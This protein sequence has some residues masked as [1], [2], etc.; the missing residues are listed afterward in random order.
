MAT[1]KDLEDPWWRLNNLYYIK[2]KK[3][4]KVLFKAN[5]AQRLFYAGMWYLN[6]VLKAR[7]LGLTT[8]IQLFM[9]DRCLFTPNI[10]AGV[11]AHNR[12]DAQKFFRDK[13]KFAY[14]NL[15]QALKDRIQATNDSAGELVFS[16][17]SSIR[18]GTSMRSGTL[19]Y[20]HISEFGKTCAKFPEKAAEII[21]GALNTVAPGQFVFIESTAEGDFGHFRD[22]CKA[23]EALDCSGEQLTTMDYKFFFFPWWKHPDYVLDADVLISQDLQDYFAELE[24]EEGIVLTREQKAWYAKKDAEQGANMRQEYPATSTEAFQKIVEGAIYGKEMRKAMQE[25]RIIHLPIDPTYKVFTFWDLGKRDTNSIWFMQ[26]IGPWYHWIDYYAN[27]LLGPEHYAKVL[28]ER[29][30]QYGYQYA[31]HYMPHDVGVEDYSAVN[32]SRQDIYER[33]GVKPIMRVQRIPDLELGINLTR[34]MLA[35]SRFDRERCAEGIQGLQAYRYMYDEARKTFHKIPIED[36]ASHP[37]DAIR[38]C[39]QAFKEESGFQSLNKPEQKPG[40]FHRKPSQKPAAQ[41][42]V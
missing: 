40:A 12:E 31:M 15:P 36:F 27:N 18:V 19:Q 41:W 2:D 25:R 37:S 11:I 9:L 28:K 22:M 29:A 13:I 38:Q 17:G 24:K 4:Q 7:Q 33:L 14:D 21:S 35:S 1:A 16:N 5:W 30:D 10:T 3:G 23:A 20:L 34:R 42:V 26:K 32:E 6:I 39:A 8:I